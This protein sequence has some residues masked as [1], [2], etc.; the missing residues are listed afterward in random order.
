MDYIFIQAI[1]HYHG[2]MEQQNK[3][4]QLNLSLFIPVN[5]GVVGSF[6]P[7]LSGQ[8]GCCEVEYVEGSPAENV[9]QDHH[10]QN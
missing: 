3:T 5:P 1:P 6:T 2:Y 4:A 9:D 7:A 10:N 8:K